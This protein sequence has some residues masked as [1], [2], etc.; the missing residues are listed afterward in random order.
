MV[1]VWPVVRVVGIGEFD[2]SVDFLKSY[3][4]DSIPEVSLTGNRESFYG[5]P[6]FSKTATL[7]IYAHPQDSITF[8]APGF[9]P[10]RLDNSLMYVSSGGSVR[11]V[12][13][14]HLTLPTKRIV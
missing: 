14:T 6:D 9:S 10:A 2:T 13:Y 1:E 3:C 5:Y 4:F 12:S 8:K 11:T 7:S